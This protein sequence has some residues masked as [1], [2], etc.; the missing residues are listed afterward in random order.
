M[1]QRKRLAQYTPEK[2]LT[3]SNGLVECAQAWGASSFP[4]ANSQGIYMHTASKNV[5]FGNILG[6]K[7]QHQKMVTNRGIC[8]MGDVSTNCR[9]CVSWR[10]IG[11]TEKG[12]C[13][14]EYPERNSEVTDR[15][16]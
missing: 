8:P 11:S 16:L 15:Q 12:T 3:K 7:I 6:R 1:H 2:V 14:E 9:E 5:R 4:T 10:A 13:R